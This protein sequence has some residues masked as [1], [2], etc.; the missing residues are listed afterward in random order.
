MECLHLQLNSSYEMESRDKDAIEKTISQLNTSI[1]GMRESSHTIVEEVRGKYQ[2][3]LDELM[4]QE[5]EFKSKISYL[6]K[7]I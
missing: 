6:Q 1:E 4:H 7:D 2:P 3:P 5:M